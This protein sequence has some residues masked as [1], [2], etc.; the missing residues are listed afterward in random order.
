MTGLGLVTAA[1]VGV[2][3]TWQ[4]LL[5]GRSTATRD[6]QLA[7]MP[8]DFSCRAPHF[9]PDA[10][11]GRR[12]TWR[13]DR[14]TQMA[15]IAAR[16]A[17]Q[18]AQLDLA[19]INRRRV[20]VVLG[21]ASASTDRWEAEVAKLGARR[22][23]DMSPLMVPRSSPNMV[24]AEI[25]LHFD[26]QGPSFTVNTACASGATAIGVARELLDGACDIVLAGGAE[27]ACNRISSA[28]FG[29]MGAL[30]RQGHCPK[31]ACRPFAPDRDGFVLGEGAGI[32]LLETPVHAKARGA[33]TRAHLCGYAAS[34][35]AH[36]PTSPHP[37]GRGAVQALH[38]ALTDARL[39]PDEIDHI[40]AHGTATVMNDRIEAQALHTVF[41]SPPPVTA[42]KATL[43][44]AL[45]A[46][47]A[48]EAACT[49]LTLQHQAIPPTA[50][51]L[52][53][54]LDH[55]LDLVTKAPRQTPMNAAVSSSFGFGGQNAVL[56]FNTP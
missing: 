39:H 11:L 16:E 47:G 31:H 48:I 25:S 46:S 3:K 37:Q 4:G 10:T 2:E 17:V 1:G 30:S 8:V 19:A 55:Q 6:P 33:P 14:H 21:V 12:L 34:C 41:G 29:Q 22:V 13:L 36:H 9:D 24:A 5:A 28:S 7:G 26:L 56:V 23:K 15:L 49:V 51:S 38:D 42:T 44:H 40:N 32:L 54:E 20:G 27:S 43:G 52:R 45:G 53:Q 35:D 18:D 50:N